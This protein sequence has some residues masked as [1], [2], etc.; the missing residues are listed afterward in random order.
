MTLFSNGLDFYQDC[1]IFTLKLHIAICRASESC[2]DWSEA[3]SKAIRTF[4]WDSCKLSHGIHDVDD[5]LIENFNYHRY[6]DQKVSSLESV[7]NS[8]AKNHGYHEQLLQVGLGDNTEFKRT[9]MNWTL[10]PHLFT[11]DFKYCPTFIFPFSEDDDLIKQ[12][13]NHSLL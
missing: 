10:Y 3:S 8:T 12:L 4:E 11:S 13:A 9:S 7:V 5:Q 6:V 2:R 1:S